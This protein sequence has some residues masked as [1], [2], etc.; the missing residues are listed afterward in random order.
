[1][2]QVKTILQNVLI[3]WDRRQQ[4]EEER[5]RS[6]RE[7]A[8]GLTFRLNMKR[9][10]EEQIRAKES[11]DAPHDGRKGAIHNDLLITQAHQ[12]REKEELRPDIDTGEDIAREKTVAVLVMPEEPLRHTKFC[13][14]DFDDEYDEISGSLDW[15]D[16]SLA[17]GSQ[18]NFSA[19]A[20]DSDVTTMHI[21]ETDNSYSSATVNMSTYTSTFAGG[22]E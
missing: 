5:M 21:S 8:R 4:M 16:D 22:E 10:V 15:N 18:I 19:V 17:V 12:S 6:L 11:R 1:M 9:Y 2:K 3:Y 20:F 14:T 13:E 7:K